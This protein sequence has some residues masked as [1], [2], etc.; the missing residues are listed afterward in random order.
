M[1]GAPV[2]NCARNAEIDYTHDLAAFR[3]AVASPSTPP[4]ESWSP[5]IVKLA[6]HELE[7]FSALCRHHNLTLMDP[8]DRQLADLAAVRKPSAGISERQRLIDEMVTV[9]G[10][11]EAH[12]RWI[13]LPWEAKVVHLLGQEAYFEVITNRNHNKITRDEQRLLR[14]KRVGVIGLS[15]GGEAAVT[16][17][18]EH[19]C[20]E[21]VLA[22]FDRLDLS[23]LNRLNAG[24]DDLGQNKAVLVARRIARIDPYLKV[25]VLE[26]GVTESN[27]NDFLAGL[28]LL[29]EECDGLHIKHEV[30]R[31]ARE[32]GLNIVFAADEKG[33]L[34]IEPYAYTPDLHVFHGRI[35][36]PQSTREAFSCPLAF[37][38]ALT[39]WMGG[40]NQISERSRRSLEQIGDTLCGYP[41]LATE[42]RYA[43]AQIGHVARRLLLGELLSPFM[44]NLDLADMVS[45]AQNPKITAPSS[46]YRRMIV[47]R[48]FCRS[49]LHNEV[50]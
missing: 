10:G 43:A 28:D 18:Q 26:D 6:P 49:K 4:A 14:A 7:A 15:V 5:W 23:N 46:Q 37:M 33:F 8:I 27:L 11:K 29:I 19:L 1:S 22:D 40:W 45:P 17:A 39:E 44:G 35:E 21:I 12:G 24:F 38:Q 30:R 13:Y 42:A 50:Q 41:Q 34:S 47:R 9:S 20:G 31:R 48:L 2:G 25:R 3:D 36:V 32:R 16:V